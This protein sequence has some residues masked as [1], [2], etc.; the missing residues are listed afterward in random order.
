MASRSLWNY[1]R[2]EVNH[3]ANENNAENFKTNNN[4]TITSKDFK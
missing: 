4:K 2:D 1:H 3:D